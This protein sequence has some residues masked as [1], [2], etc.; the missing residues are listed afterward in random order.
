MSN[1][2]QATLAPFDPSIGLADK[3]I[4]LVDVAKAC[5]RRVGVKPSKDLSKLA[6]DVKKILK[7]AWVPSHKIYINYE[8]QRWP[9]PKHIKK[10]FTKWNINCVTPLQCRYDPKEDRY[11]GSDG[12][13]HMIVWLLYY[14]LIS[15]VPCFYVESED[16]NVE[17]EQ[18]L[19]LNTENEPMAKFFI[20]KQ[21]IKMGNQESIAIEKA[22]VDANCETSYKKRAPGCITHISH[23][24]EA[25]EDYGNA[26]LTNVLARYREFWP[27]DKIAEP[28]ILGFLKLRELLID[29]DKYS[30][31][32][33]KDTFYYCSQH[34][35]SGKDFHLSV[36]HAFQKTYP[37]N[38]KGMGVREKVAS[39]II[40]IYEQCDNKK[41]IDKPF[42]ITVPMIPVTYTL[43]DDN[44]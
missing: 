24:Y 38:Y 2:T 4:P 19:A 15:E 21:K 27:E 28:T 8:R 20:H 14:G 42:D 37:T 31:S 5:A 3:R 30:D 16:P 35:V 34:F 39:G 26:A 6:H 7:F 43:N 1:S 9:E 40:S 44:D 18:L 13:Q 11:Y 23:L 25:S 32:L 36:N 29:A 41:L 22:V 17:S 12:M 33:F 10:L